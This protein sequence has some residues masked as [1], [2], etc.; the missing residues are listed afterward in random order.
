MT[1]TGRPASPQAGHA[2]RYGV[3][4]PYVPAA[5]V[6]AG[7]LGLVVGVVMHSIGLV[8]V[9]LIF[10]VQ[11]AVFLHTTLRGK[12]VTWERLL[13][14]LG[15]QGSE[16][17][18]DVGCGRGAVLIAAALRVPGGAAHGLDLWRSQDQSGNAEAVTQG[19]AV[20]AGVGDRVELH[21]GNMTGM[22]FACD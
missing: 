3:D 13:D 8:I 6:V 22:P 19:N 17:M 16:A 9:G 1:S 20:A 21:T 2:L 15:L 11:A 7:S 10:L 5:F 14:R 4:A 18:L 12:F